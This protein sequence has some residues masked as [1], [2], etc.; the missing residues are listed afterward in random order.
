MLWLQ[1]H[2][3]LQ[4]IPAARVRQNTCWGWPHT[5]NAAQLLLLLLWRPMLLL[6]LLQGWRRLVL[7]L[8]QRML[9]KQRCGGKHWGGRA[10]EVLVDDGDA[11]VWRRAAAG[12]G[13]PASHPQCCRE[14]SRLGS[15]QGV[16][17]R[18]LL[19]LLVRK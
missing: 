14:E 7:L 18:L 11:Q 10:A 5:A 8:L 19:Q 4:A 2:L 12:P 15:G 17:P 16:Q 9:N 6:L 13:R 3:V 1:Q